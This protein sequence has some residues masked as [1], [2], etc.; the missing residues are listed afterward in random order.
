MPEGGYTKR[1]TNRGDRGVIGLVGERWSLPRFQAGFI[2]NQYGYVITEIYVPPSVF[3]QKF[4]A[5]ATYSCT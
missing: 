3:P 2:S 5:G 1:Y 4:P